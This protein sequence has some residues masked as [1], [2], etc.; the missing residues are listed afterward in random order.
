MEI[1]PY[2]TVLGTPGRKLNINGLKRN[3]ILCT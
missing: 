2:L 3:T 1:G